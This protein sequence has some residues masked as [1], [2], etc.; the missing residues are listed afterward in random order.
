MAIRARVLGTCRVPDPTEVGT[1]T[2]FYPWVALV[3]DLN[4]DGYFFPPASDLTGT[5]CFTTMILDCQQ[6]KMCSF[7]Y[8]D[9]DLC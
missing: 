7:Y 1:G 3:P 2:S 5:Q 9:Y 4:R 8:I 6:V